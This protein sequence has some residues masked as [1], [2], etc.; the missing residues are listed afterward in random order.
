MIIYILEFKKL[1]KSHVIS[2]NVINHEGNYYMGYIS[3]EVMIEN[4]MFFGKH[5]IT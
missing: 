2:L 5:I 1:K 4:L 3:A